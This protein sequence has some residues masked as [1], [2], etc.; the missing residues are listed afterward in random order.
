MASIHRSRLYYFVEQGMRFKV[1]VTL[2]AWHEQS[3]IY[4]V[5]REFLDRAPENSKCVGL[6]C[7]YT[8]AVKNVKQKNLLPEKK[9]CHRPATLYGVRD[10]GLPD[11]P[12][13]CSAG[14]PKGVPE[15]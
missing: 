6:D 15:Q 8:I 1:T 9:Q 11:M 12:R 7:E 10:S 3:W 14:A 2:Q 13:G 5:H 4:R